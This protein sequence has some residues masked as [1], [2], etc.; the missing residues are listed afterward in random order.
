[1]A[2]ALS[3]PTTAELRTLVSACGFGTTPPPEITPALTELATA[4][5]LAPLLGARL[6]AG[7][8]TAPESV[9]A[10][11]RSAYRSCALANTA[12]ELGTSVLTRSLV[13]AGIPVLLLKGAALVRTVYRDPGRRSM[14][15]VDLLVPP[16]RWRQALEVVDRVGARPVDAPDRP[17]TLRHFHEVHLRLAAGGLVDLHRQLVPRP[18]FK[19]DPG[20]LFTT[21]GEEPDGVRVPAPEALFVSLA[22]H[23]A[24]DGF[25]LPL[26]SVVD[27]LALIADSASGGG[28]G[29]EVE[30][31]VEVEAEA[32]GELARRW[33]ARRATARYLQLLERFG[34]PT[35]SWVAL[36]RSLAPRLGPAPPELGLERP[37]D[38]MALG[39]RLRCRWRGAWL[40]DGPLRPLAYNALWLLR[41]GRDLVESRWTR[42]TSSPMGDEP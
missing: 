9:S 17:A 4:E 28:S 6:A 15:D 30:V 31:E 5:G 36:A 42:S 25:F 29:A 22:L 1:M 41:F 38:P 18:L 40:Q 21:A 26:R 35:E 24:K 2:P 16:E 20:E 8:L 19:V 23:A 33:A 11:L 34:A 27:G 39:H 37:A 10:A 12:L 14:G 7:E 32:V 3:S 13:A